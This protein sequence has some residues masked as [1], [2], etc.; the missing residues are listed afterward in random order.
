MFEQIVNILVNFAHSLGYI[1]IYFYMFLVGTFIPVP[2]E[3]V[4]LPAGYLAAKGDMDLFL[5]WLCAALGS[6]S[7]ALFNYFL[8]KW[9]VNKFLKDK[10]IIKKVNKFWYS[11]GKISAFLAPLTP[12]LGQYISIPA[13]LSH[14]SLKWFIPLTFSANLI[15][16][17]FLIMIGYFFG[18][19]DK[20]HKEVIYGSL[21]LLGGVIL[22]ASIYV[23]REIKKSKQ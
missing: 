10:P 17:G 23:L 2:S 11:H 21:I 7:G 13:G 1:G 4:L 22:I 16:T 14:M 9:I 3:L 20:A 6:L 19:G 12:G 18:A 15:W 5:V 8:A